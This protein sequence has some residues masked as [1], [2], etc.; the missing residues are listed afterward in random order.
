MTLAVT[1][2]A[3][4][5]DGIRDR[6]RALGLLERSA[7]TSFFYSPVGGGGRMLLVLQPF[8]YGAQIYL[9]PEALGRADG[10]AQW[11]YALL[12]GEGFGMGSK[13]GPSISLPL[14]DAARMATFWTAFERL[15]CG[16]E[17]ER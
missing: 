2:P 5:L 16:T 9:Y 1:D 8:G 11:F 15:L 14:G 7:G 6:F 3:V 10:A 13:A 12:E 4:P 17:H